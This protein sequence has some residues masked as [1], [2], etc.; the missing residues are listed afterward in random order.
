MASDRVQQIRMWQRA[1]GCCIMC[2]TT[3]AL[4]GRKQDQ[5]QSESR[6]IDA[7]I[8]EED[9]SEKIEESPARVCMFRF[10]LL[11]S[12]ERCHVIDEY[13][14]LPP[15]TKFRDDAKA[16]SESSK[17]ANIKD[18]DDETYSRGRDLCVRTGKKWVVAGCKDCN[19]A[20]NR[21]VENSLSVVQA[22]WGEG[23][24]ALSAIEKLNKRN[25]MYTL[26]H[27]VALFF[28]R[29]D[30]GVWRI[31]TREDTVKTTCLY[32]I[33]ANLGLWGKTGIFRFRCIAIFYASMYIRE[34][35]EEVD[36]LT[37]EDWHIHCFRRF[38]T[39]EYP[40]KNLTFFGMQQSEATALYST[41]ELKFASRWLS[42]IEQRLKLFM[43]RM[44][45]DRSKTT[46]D[47]MTIARLHNDL[48]S[49]ATD[50]DALLLWAVKNWKTHSRAV[51]GLL[52]FLFY[53]IKDD[54]SARLLRLRSEA[55][56]KAVVPAMKQIDGDG[57]YKRTR[58]AMKRVS[59]E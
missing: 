6:D 28:K 54:P 58:S 21:K 10:G 8:V 45:A 4:P 3:M 33:V 51:K 43:D 17:E 44:D 24:L 59:F 57:I 31:R 47:Y 18:I 32:R 50:E 20:M 5:A 46:V 22:T 56:A 7:P 40:D 30:D 38:Y 26:L 27:Q 29:G 48:S 15:L 49:S 19:A 52:W 39:D 14:H 11:K 12:M 42:G 13:A 53:N 1:L 55:F 9:E 35:R 37:A 23:S 2:G 25:E 16:L 36:A 34:A 41:S